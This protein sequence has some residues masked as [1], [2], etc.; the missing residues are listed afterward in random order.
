MKS[1]TKS[2]ALTSFASL[3]LMLA[4]SASAINGTWS[5]GGTG[6]VVAHHYHISSI[7]HMLSTLLTLAHL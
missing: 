6:V 1:F 5:A 2:V 7:L 4:P 3:F